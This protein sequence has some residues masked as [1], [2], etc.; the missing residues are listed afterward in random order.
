ML[1]TVRFLCS[2]VAAFARLV[3]ELRKASS[4]AMAC[5]ACSPVV[6]VHAVVAVA[7]PPAGLVSAAPLAPRKKVCGA[8]TAPGAVQKQ[9]VVV[10]PP[11]VLVVAAAPSNN[12]V[13][14]GSDDE[15]QK[16]ENKRKKTAWSESRRPS[17]LVIPVADDAGEVAAGWGAAAAPVKEVNVEVEGEDFCVASRAGPRHAMED[18][19]SVVT[20]KNDGDSQMAFYGVFDG[21]G[22]RA[23]VDFVSERLG[24]NVVSAVL[25]AG[26]ETRREASLAE[27]DAVSAAIRA[28]YLA[29]DSELLAQYQ[30]DVISGGACATT[31]LVKNADLYVAHLG[32][33]RA[34]LSRDGG[35]AVALTADHTCAREDER[36]R[37]ERDGGYVSR[38]GSGVWRVQGSLAVSRSFGDVGLKRWVVAEPAV[39][40]V[41]L[42]AGCEFLVIA[43]DGLWDKVT[44]QEAVDAVSRSS[45]TA[46]GELVELARRR[47]SRDDVTVMVVDL[48]R[49]VR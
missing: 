27:E 42:S 39:A 44:N 7:A 37:I 29:T 26:T 21:H 35:A 38:S 46:C 31:A 4:I 3:R 14:S 32:D 49:F 36:E 10:A 20:H 30:Q 16:A 2:V 8:A 45:A 9:L 13:G 48:E 1:H 15:E 22:G 28:A 17:R 11:P 34:V 6:C 40:R 47:G 19:Y 25:A 23:A 41:P 43:S 18:A 33:C 5:A 12:V 24:K